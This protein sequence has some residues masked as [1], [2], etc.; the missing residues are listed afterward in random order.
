MLVS[1]AEQGRYLRRYHKTHPNHLLM[2]MNG[3]ALAAVSW[4][5]VA[6][7]REW[8]D[9]AV[10]T[11]L[12]QP[13]AQFYPDGAQ[14][15]L[16][17][18]YHL[19][20]LVHLE[21][22]ARIA[23]GHPRVGPDFARG[24]ER[25]W[26]Y[27]AGTLRPDGNTPL[28]NDSDLVCLREVLP[29]MAE[30]YRRPDWTHIA[31]GGEKGEP[32]RSP[33]S[34]FFPWAGQLVMRSGWS[35]DAHWAF[36]DAGPLGVSGHQHRDKLHLGV[37][38]CGR[39]LLVDGGRY[40]YRWDVWRQYFL[41]SASHNTLLV[42]GGGQ[43]DDVET[44]SEP[45]AGPACCTALCDYACASFGAGYIGAAGTAVHTRAVLYLRGYAWLV[46]DRLQTDRP[47]TVQAL[48]HFHPDCGVERQGAD[49]VS[50]DPGVGNLRI[51]PLA[52]F[53]W[54]LDLVKGATDPDPGRY[55][56]WK[57]DIVRRPDDPQIQGWYSPH[58]N[59]RLPCATAVY[60]ADGL[61]TAA[62]AWLLTPARG[63]VPALVPRV[64]A[65]G[66]DGE[67]RI[68][69]PTAAGPV[70][71]VRLDLNSTECAAVRVAD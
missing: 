51:T 3:L 40:W 29:R 28:N 13:R 52:A 71:D 54:R 8:L 24:L 64:D 47:R 41:G 21:Q 5:E 23:A 55:R 50:V 67:I 56:M 46:V 45:F 35:R 32:P 38:A 15:E 36:F 69:V 34:R 12:P 6:A 49:A 2:E 68:A 61:A 42:D 60:R 26:E 33:P 58:Y 70:F 9:Y 39:D 63:A 37:Y 19:V 1:V 62:F 17:A 65:L 30:R 11:V 14:T 27:A 44:V 22:F 20:S 25:F 7:A 48:W 10:A 31:S 18:G 43:A 4:P 66:P 53:A 59:T 57:A 16:T